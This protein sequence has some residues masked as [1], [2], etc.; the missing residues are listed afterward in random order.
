VDRKR[1]ERYSQKFRCRTVERMYACENILRLSRELGIHRRLLYK[2]RDQVDPAD[3]E[4]DGE[5]TPQTSRESTL[6]KEISKLKR[7]LADKTVEV[8]YFRGA[9]QKVEARRQQ[10]DISGEKAST[11]KSKTRL[12][13]SLSIERMCQLAQV[14]RAGSYRYLQGRAPVEDCIRTFAGAGGCA[15]AR[16]PKYCYSRS[17]WEP[18]GRLSIWDGKKRR[19]TIREL[20]RSGPWPAL[21]CAQTR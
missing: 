8:D 21:R 4:A 2:W 18:V 1:G 7:L 5:L 19:C 16:C 15:S 12:Q 11:M 13:G 20:G 3:T 17:V 6:R 9:L 14:S 10:S